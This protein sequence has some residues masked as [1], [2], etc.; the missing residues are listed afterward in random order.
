[1]NRVHPLATGERAVLEELYRQTKEADVRS[2]CQMIFLSHEGLSPPQVA[3][4]VRCHRRTVTRYI[5]RYEAEGIAGLLTRPR[6]G[7]PPKATAAYEALLLQVVAQEPRTLALPFSNW[8]TAHLAEYLSRKTAVELSPRQ[9]EN[10][11]KTNGWRLRRPM[12]TV[13]HKQDPA[14]VEEKKTTP[15]GHG[16]GG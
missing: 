8:T 4:Q 16:S 1:M 7:R 3:Q 10:I 9:V 11:L 2:R 15:R 5:Q 6:S 13:A 14:L 12:S